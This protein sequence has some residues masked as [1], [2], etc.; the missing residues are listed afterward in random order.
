MDREELIRRVAERTQG[1]SEDPLTSGTIG[2][3]VDATL[4]ELGGLGALDD[5]ADEPGTEPP[6]P[7]AS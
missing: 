6:E 7:V 4:K 1:T 2:K 3:V 5:E